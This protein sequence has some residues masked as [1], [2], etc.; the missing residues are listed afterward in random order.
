MSTSS[1][2]RTVSPRL[3]GRWGLVVAL[4]LPASGCTYSGGE[5]LFALGF[6]S[7]RKVPA[8]FRL[9][10]APLMI[11][12]DDIHEHI[13]WPPARRALFD[14]LSQ[15]LLRHKAAKK[16][17][18][19]ATLEQLQQSVPK[20]DQRGCREIGEI[21]GAEQVL[22]LEVRDFVADEEIF[23]ANDA[24]YVAVTVKVINVRET[25][26]RSRVR[27]WPVS[28]DGH[29]VTASMSGSEVSIKKDKDDIVEEL[30]KR[31]AADVARLFYD[32]RA[33]EFERPP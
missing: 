1:I 22:W 5:L 6:G 3:A 26:R 15:E 7:G 18:P 23:D 13:D 24:A 2:C 29:L 10:D 8:E 14:E 28:P 11:F 32:H 16:I 27:L 20:F 33:P 17:I 31:L 12:I 25:K 19:L 30:A 21:A 4:A 9:T